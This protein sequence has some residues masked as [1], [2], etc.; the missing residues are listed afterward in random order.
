MKTL[1]RLKSRQDVIFLT[2]R[3]KVDQPERVNMTAEEEVDEDDD[4]PDFKTFKVST[5]DAHF[6]TDHANGT[7]HYCLTDFDVLVSVVRIKN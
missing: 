1:I 5:E 7:A 6:F 3:L 4:I 2:C